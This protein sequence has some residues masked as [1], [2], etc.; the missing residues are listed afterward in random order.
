MRASAHLY[1][2]LASPSKQPHLVPLAPGAVSRSAAS[3]VLLYQPVSGGGLGEECGKLQRAQDRV[4]SHEQ[5][6]LAG[7]HSTAAWQPRHL[8]SCMAATSPPQ[9]HGSHVTSTAAWQ[10]RHLHSCM[11]A[12]SPP[13]THIHTHTHTCTCRSSADSGEPLTAVAIPNS[14][15][16]TVHESMAVPSQP[17]LPPPCL[18]CSVHQVSSLS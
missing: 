7:E 15:L 3:G 13:R 11:A 17:C 12:T 6:S 2:S 18:A 4:L 5:G 1:A 16:V 14:F 10:P 8:H 9:L